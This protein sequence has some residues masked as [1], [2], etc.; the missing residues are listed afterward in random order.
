MRRLPLLALVLAFAACDTAGLVGLRV[1]DLSKSPADLV[2]TWDLRSVTSSGFGGPATTR[3]AVD[4]GRS[5]S[6]TFRADGTAT[7]VSDGDSLETTWEVRTVPFEY[8][9]GR[10]RDAVDLQIGER[11]RINFGVDGD[12]LYFDDRYRD[13]SLS[14]YARRRAPAR[15]R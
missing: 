13:G 6:Y 8:E 10:F 3:S 12:R 14:E 9:A 7:R 2:G 5:E 4:L 15:A 1:D 11:R